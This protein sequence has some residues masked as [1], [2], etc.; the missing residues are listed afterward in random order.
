MQ[1]PS[2]PTHRMRTRKGWGRSST[3]CV[4]PAKS[5]T[6]MPDYTTTTS[7]TM[8]QALAGTCRAIP[9]PASSVLEVRPGHTA[10]DGC[11]RINGEATPSDGCGSS[12]LVIQ[13]AP[14]MRYLS[15]FARAWPASTL[16]MRLSGS[17]VNRV[18]EFAGCG[19]HLR[20]L[21]RRTDRGRVGL[22]LP[23]E[24]QSRAKGTRSS[25]AANCG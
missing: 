21:A 15:M 11:A 9:V 17:K 16:G 24:S 4:I 5:T 13:R 19:V 18:R 6:P 25:A 23:P 1:A 20:V 22:H 10:Q 12:A 2:A 7:E 8:T 3:T 14:A